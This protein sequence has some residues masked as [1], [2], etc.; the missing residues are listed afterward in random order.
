MTMFHLESGKKV[1]DE[2]HKDFHFRKVNGKWSID[3]P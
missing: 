1:A 2:D 3:V